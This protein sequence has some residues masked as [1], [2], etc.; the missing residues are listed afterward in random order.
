MFYFLNQQK[1][2]VRLFHVESITISISLIYAF[3]KELKKES[4]TLKSAHAI[5]DNRPYIY[6]YI[7]LSGSF[8]TCSQYLSTKSSSHVQ[9]LSSTIWLHLLCNARRCSTIETLPSHWRRHTQRGRDNT[10]KLALINHIPQQVVLCVFFALSRP[11][12]VFRSTHVRYSSTQSHIPSSST[13][14]IQNWRKEVE[15]SFQSSFC[16]EHLCNSGK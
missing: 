8:W 1:F 13:R 14:T 6:L 15:F 4:F 3:I 12:R 7:T 5:A 10:T 2:G 9:H 16:R 11:Q